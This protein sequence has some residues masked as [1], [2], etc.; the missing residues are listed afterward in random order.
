M[1]RFKF[2]N[3]KYYSSNKKMPIL[4]NNKQIFRNLL[5]ITKIK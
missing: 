1:I 4:T 2:K 3:N 5:Q